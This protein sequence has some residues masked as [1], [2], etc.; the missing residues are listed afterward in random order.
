MLKQW[1]GII[2]HM[3]YIYKCTICFSDA[4]NQLV[5][6]R[7]LRRQIKNIDSKSLFFL[8][9]LLHVQIQVQLCFC[10]IHQVTLW[11]EEM[12]LPQ[13]LSPAHSP[14]GNIS[15]AIYKCKTNCQEGEDSHKRT[16]RN[17]GA[18]S[19]EVRECYNKKTVVYAIRNRDN[20]LIDCSIR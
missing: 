7:P 5:S 2:H 11:V 1:R 3:I 15:Y 16:Y 12:W 13:G 17:K 10:L 9:G 6:Q 19:Q 14:Y 18:K 20:H 4:V 8:T